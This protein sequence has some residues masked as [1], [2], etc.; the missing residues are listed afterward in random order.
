MKVL[1]VVVT[2][3]FLTGCAWT[4]VQQTSTE[5]TALFNDWWTHVG[6]KE[7]Q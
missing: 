3:A 4:P 1:Q 6:K 2:A 5:R 7:N